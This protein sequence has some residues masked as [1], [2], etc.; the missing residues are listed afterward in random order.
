MDWSKIEKNV[1]FH[2]TARLKSHENP[3]ASSRLIPHPNRSTLNSYS[4]SITHHE[5]DFSLDNKHSFYSH[6]HSGGLGEDKCSVPDD[7][8]ESPVFRGSNM[9]A[10]ALITND[11]DDIKATL[12]KQNEKIKALEMAIDKRDVALSVASKQDLIQERVDRMEVDLQGCSKYIQSISQESSDLSVQA[13]ACSGRLSFVEEMYRSSAQEYV[14]KNTFSQ[15]LTSCMDQLKDINTLVE[16]ARTKGAQAMQFVESFLAAISHLQSS[17]PSFSLE[18]LIGLSGDKQKEQISRAISEALKGTICREVQ[19]G[20]SRMRSVIESVNE[21]VKR[22]MTIT[23]QEIREQISEHGK[24]L[25]EEVFRN[26]EISMKSIQ[27]I[28]KQVDRQKRMLEAEISATREAQ[29]VVEIEQSDGRLALQRLEDTVS[30]LQSMSVPAMQRNHKSLVDEVIRIDS[31]QSASASHLE[32]LDKTV[33]RLTAQLKQVTKTTAALEHTAKSQEGGTDS[34]DGGQRSGGPAF[35]PD[36]CKACQV[37][38][39]RLDALEEAMKL[40]SATTEKVEA[41]MDILQAELGSISKDSDKKSLKLEKVQADFIIHKAGVAEMK[42]SLNELKTHGC[43]VAKD[44]H[45]QLAAIQSERQVH[46]ED[47]TSPL[48][49]PPPGGVKGIAATPGKTTATTLGPTNAL[50]DA[51]AKTKTLTATTSSIASTSTSTSTPPPKHP[52]HQV[53]KKKVNKV[54]PVAAKEMSS[55]PPKKSQVSTS[56]KDSESKETAQEQSQASHK[57]NS[58]LLSLKVDKHDDHDDDDDHDHLDHLSEVSDSPPKMCASSQLADSLDESMNDLSDQFLGH[59]ITPVKV[60]H[61]P[62]ERSQLIKASLEASESERQGDLMIK[63]Y[64]LGSEGQG[65]GGKGGP[66]EDVDEDPEDDIDAGPEDDDDDSSES[67]DSFEE[68]ADVDSGDIASILSPKRSNVTYEISGEEEV[69][70]SGLGRSES[71]EVNDDD[72]IG[73]RFDNL[74]H[75]RQN[76]SKSRNQEEDEP[77]HE[78]E[79]DA[80]GSRFDKLGNYIPPKSA[81]GRGTQP[82]TQAQTQSQAPVLSGSLLGRKKSTGSTDGGKSLVTSTSIRN[83]SGNTAY[84]SVTSRAALDGAN[85]ASQNSGPRLDNTAQCTF[86][87]RRM[88]VE[89]VRTHMKSCELRTELCKYGCRSK[90]LVIKM[91]KH[92]DICAKNPE[93]MNK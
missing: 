41:S 60:T 57:P 18:F 10:Q 36:S 55:P 70:S 43:P 1:Q 89:D 16:G 54:P 42:K 15:L 91:D 58:S 47:T 46:K 51:I 8:Y 77:E 74:P 3:A 34:Q 73:S 19:E 75:S 5:D 88:P 13:K 30:K 11:L 21:D 56:G 92:L 84:S 22:E 12:L 31:E 27:D 64:D 66:E 44:C 52:V 67:S 40:L 17:Q 79:E 62:D 63:K 26:T 29:Q 35:V 81:G 48:K 90:V 49:P 7:E 61:T 85:V 65:A 33:A 25:G 76:E 82:Q 28:S 53:E 4:G 68:S 69:S 39:K 87:L 78:D 86:C 6:A 20:S 14:T 50:V 9:A 38:Q 24:E 37:S 83:S 71:N 93:N 59:H 32:D 72:K 45:S 80:I 23:L 2:T